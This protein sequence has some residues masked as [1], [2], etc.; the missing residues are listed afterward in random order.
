MY[1]VET[2][3]KGMSPMIGLRVFE[4][5]AK[6]R[7]YYYALHP[8]YDVVTLWI[9]D[10]WVLRHNRKKDRTIIKRRKTKC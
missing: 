5:P 2:I 9:D 4:D 6:A 7:D 8:Y 1:I 3:T 10:I